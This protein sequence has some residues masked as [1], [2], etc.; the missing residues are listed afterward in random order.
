MHNVAKL[1]QI[2]GNAVKPI[3]FIIPF[4]VNNIN[5]SD[6]RN[7][8]LTAKDKATHIY[9]IMDFYDI[10]DKTKE[11]LRSCLPEVLERYKRI[12]A[13]H[14]DQSYKVCC[15]FHADRNPSCEIDPA[16]G[17]YHC[18]G[19]GASGDVF[20][21]VAQEENLD[22][23]KGQDFQRA[24]KVIA[25]IG[26]IELKPKTLGVGDNGKGVFS[27]ID[28]PE[29][30]LSPS[31]T[32]VTPEDVE[33]YRMNVTGSNLYNYLCSLYSSE[34][35]NRVLDLY[36]IGATSKKGTSWS[37]F[38]LINADGDCVDIHLMPYNVNGH[39]I[40]YNQWRLKELGQ[41]G[42]R[43]PW[44]LF[45][46]HLLATDPTAPVGLVESEKTALISALAAP[47]FIWMAT[48]SKA[49]FNEKRCSAILD[50]DCYIFPDVDGVE[51]WRTQGTA[52]ADKG[53][54]L[55][56]AGDYITRHA[57]GDHDD[58]ADIIAR[59]RNKARDIQAT[60]E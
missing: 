15:P 47:E 57:T 40:N 59:C 58:L 14:T 18:Y 20:S 50:R 26:K 23:S 6:C 4:V 28:V 1:R 51:T 34:D 48:L 21:L 37:A 56:W 31:W 11:D 16:K 12:P 38:P 55:Y 41:N 46:E 30:G 44:P 35:V 3:P 8:G 19:C 60:R 33:R 10:D 13:K 25:D 43:A 2:C 7:C 32:Y 54:M 52:M 22:L 24:A 29:D 5:R 36:R 27:N 39:R 53:F 45:G 17:V 42:L 49:N 9:R